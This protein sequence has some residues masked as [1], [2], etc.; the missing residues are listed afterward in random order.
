MLNKDL[1]DKDKL[2]KIQ[3]EEL[4]KLRKTIYS[5]KRYDEVRTRHYKT[6]LERI[7]ELESILSKFNLETIDGRN[8]L[9]HKYITLQ[10]KY[11]SLQAILKSKNESN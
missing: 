11:K 1:L 4:S 9:L 10:K 2:I 8:N 6:A 3:N 5:F 7:E